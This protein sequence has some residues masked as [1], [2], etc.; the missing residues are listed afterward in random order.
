M[1]SNA[2]GSLGEPFALCPKK[3]RTKSSNKCNPTGNRLIFCSQPES[4]KSKPIGFRL[5]LHPQYLNTNIHLQIHISY[6]IPCQFD[7]KILKSKSFPLLFYTL[8]KTTH[9]LRFA[10]WL[11]FFTIS[12]GERLVH[13]H[14][15]MLG[16]FV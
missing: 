1:S 12:P 9:L 8:L 14:G 4:D 7:I 11:N 5:N 3:S 13:L 2:C 10:F 16:L 15:Q 6:S